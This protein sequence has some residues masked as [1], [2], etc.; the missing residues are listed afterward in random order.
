[1]EGEEHL[2]YPVSFHKSFFFPREGLWYPALENKHTFFFLQLGTPHGTVRN[3]WQRKKRNTCCDFKENEKVAVSTA[4]FGPDSLLIFYP[5][6]DLVSFTL[7]CWSR[8]LP[9][10]S[11]SSPACDN[12]KTLSAD[13]QIRNS[14]ANEAF[15]VACW[16]TLLARNTL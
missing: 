2:E 14:P 3:N 4:S 9:V 13:H 12:L 11:M 8:K 1:M 6:Q 10:P 15:E 7:W 16:Q 5:S